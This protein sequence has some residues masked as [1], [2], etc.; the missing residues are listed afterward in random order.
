MQHH[1][2]IEELE[3]RLNLSSV[4]PALPI[5]APTILRAT[6]DSTDVPTPAHRRDLVPTGRNRY[7]NLE[8]GFTTVFA[9]NEDGPHKRLTITVPP[10]T[11]I[12]DD[13]RPRTVHN[14]I[15]TRES[16]VLEPDTE[17]F[18][19]YAPGVGLVQD[20]TLGLVSHS[21]LDN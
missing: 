13:A 2:S 7:W 16:S 10:K 9:G 8:P 3:A 12:I 15:Q 18:K 19:L 5:H 17:E 14:A 21:A 6:G 20:D 1:P 4:A 11:R